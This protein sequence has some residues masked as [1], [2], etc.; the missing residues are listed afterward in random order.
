MFVSNEE[1][2]VLLEK[3]T[4][5][6]NIERILELLDVKFKGDDF[7]P[8]LMMSL[9]ELEK[10]GLWSE[11]GD[12]I[13]TQHEWNRLCLQEHWKPMINLMERCP[14]PVV[15]IVVLRDYFSRGY[16][17]AIF[18]LSMSTLTQLYRYLP[19]TTKGNGW[20]QRRKLEV[21]I[22]ENFDW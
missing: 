21:H 18:P 5:S 8:A 16:R 12:L 13:H 2:K 15:S 22:C 7:I 20:P 10:I 4:Q 19:R 14:L 6:G 11:I 17:L 3:A 1:A 9:D